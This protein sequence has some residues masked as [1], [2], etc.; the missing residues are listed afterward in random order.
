M[1]DFFPWFDEAMVITADVDEPFRRKMPFGQAVAEYLNM[2]VV[3]IEE[4]RMRFGQQAA[5]MLEEPELTM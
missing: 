1:E 2:A 3:P 4:Y 5:R